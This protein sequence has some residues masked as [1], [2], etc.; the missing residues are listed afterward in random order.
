[1][2]FDGAVADWRD[3]LV[4]SVCA[5]AG[6]YLGK[7]LR[8]PAG[9]IVGPLILSAA[10]HLVGLTDA[11]PPFWVIIVAQVVVGT[12]LGAR[13]AGFKRRQIGKAVGLAV[14]SVAA[15][16]LLDAA[17][18]AALRTVL[19]IPFE[20]L[21]I[22]FAPGGVTETALIALS[23]DANPVFVTT[24]H[25]FRIVITVIGCSLAARLLLKK[26][27]PPDRTGGE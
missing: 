13:F 21:F 6:L 1:M 3:W 10:A 26:I 14:F 19:D 7:L 11:A 15:M 27:P 22:G 2:T 18:V 24:L 17:I 4:L 9:V 20:V 8:L 5:V 12:G 23:L 16:L 25:V